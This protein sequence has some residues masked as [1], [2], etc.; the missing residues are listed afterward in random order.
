MFFFLC[1]LKKFDFR[2]YF[3]QEMI[4]PLTL[5]GDVH[6]ELVPHKVINLNISCIDFYQSQISVSSF[7]VRS[8]AVCENITFLFSRQ[9]GSR[10]V[11][12]Y[13]IK[14]NIYTVS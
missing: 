13:G 3:Q 7:N 2:L 8:T 12:F 10:I 6:P 14:K 1:I 11:F 9:T 5:R 4:F